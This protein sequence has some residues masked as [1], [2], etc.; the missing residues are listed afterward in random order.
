MKRLLRRHRCYHCGK[1]FTKGELKW[2]L[3]DLDDPEQTVFPLVHRACAERAWQDE[4]KAEAS[5]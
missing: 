4:R 3:L 2:R 5:L 1:P